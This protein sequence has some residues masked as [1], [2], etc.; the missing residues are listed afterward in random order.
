LIDN[1]QEKGKRM[2]WSRNSGLAVLSMTAAL[3]LCLALGSLTGCARLKRW[4]GPENKDSKTQT[5]EGM[6]RQGLDEYNHGRYHGALEVF[7]K[8]KEQYPFSRY[9]MLAELKIAD[10][11]YYLG[12]YDEART[13]YKEFEKD[14]PTNEAIPYVLFQIGMTYTKQ[15]GT[16]DR[17]PAGAAES[18]Q[19]FSRL[20]RTFPQS[21]YTEEAKVRI[22]KARDFLAA[23]ELYVATF[24]LRTGEDKNAA[25]R[26][27]YLLAN[28]PDTKPAPKAQKLL[29]AIEAGD[30]PGRP[31]YTWLPL[32]GFLNP[33]SQ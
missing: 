9:S 5:A 16:I 24:Y 29:A 14:H 11:N 3:L 15:I 19:A 7:K 17:D 23:H 22:K 4:V 13:L 33:F 25:S 27:K 10:S 30:P 8:V 26:L 18:I 32:P 21:P 28:F 20:L 12:Q 1:A 2:Y 6:T 31:W